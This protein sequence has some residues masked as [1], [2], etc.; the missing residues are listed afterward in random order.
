MEYRNAQS[1]FL[2]HAAEILSRGQAVDVR[3]APTR[4]VRHASITLLNPL[5]RCIVIPG[6]NNNPFAAIY[7]TLW[8]LAGRNDISTLR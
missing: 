8:V 3:G 4:E 1:A 2:A 6:R 5:E 7:E